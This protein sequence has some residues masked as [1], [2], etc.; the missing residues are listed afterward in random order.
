M[1]QKGLGW[2]YS[3]Y[4]QVPVVNEE[5]EGKKNITFI[6]KLQI[7]VKILLEVSNLAQSLTFASHSSLAPGRLNVFASTH[8]TALSGKSDRHSLYQ[9]HFHGKCSQVL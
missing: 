6:L 8:V 1:Y 7:S 2:F 3:S 5:I 9:Q 4:R